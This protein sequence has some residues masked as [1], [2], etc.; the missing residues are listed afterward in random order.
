M[1]CASLCALLVLAVVATMLWYFCKWLR[2]LCCGFTEH[3]L[4]VVRSSVCACVAVYHQCLHGKLCRSSTKCLMNSQWCDGYRHCS[5]GEDESH[6]CNNFTMHALI[7]KHVVYL[8]S[9]ITSVDCGWMVLFSLNC[10]P[11][12]WDQLHT[13]RLLPWPWYMAA[14]VFRKMGPRL[15]EDYVWAAGIQEVLIVFFF[16]LHCILNSPLP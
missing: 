13:A 6:C 15:C 8:L 4:S 12:L 10:S 14:G 2:R 1:L 7:G 11:S 5:D 16:R 9:D 3:F